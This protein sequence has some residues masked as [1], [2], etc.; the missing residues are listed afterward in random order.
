MRCL[1]EHQ[2][3]RVYV[4]Y[5]TEHYY[6]GVDDATT[7]SKTTIFIKLTSLE[8][9]AMSDDAYW[10]AIECLY[11]RFKQLANDN[12]RTKRI[13]HKSIGGV[14]GFAG[15]YEL[16]C[17]LPLQYKEAAFR[18]RVAR[19]GRRALTV[20]LLAK[21]YQIYMN[22][23]VNR[24]ESVRV[25]S[26]DIDGPHQNMTMTLVFDDTCA[27]V[28]DAMLPRLTFVYSELTTL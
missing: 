9:Y 7:I 12:D 25:T 18:R 14:D 13:T 4:S 3:T 11:P 19:S 16:D 20:K 10:D 5:D 1:F 2:N 21:D 27:N 26:R 23:I 22:H 24:F 17:V 8:N 28:I 6:V 15:H